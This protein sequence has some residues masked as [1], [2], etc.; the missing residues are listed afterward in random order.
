MLTIFR[1]RCL[2]QVIL[3]YLQ[4]STEALDQLEKW[5]TLRQNTE[6]KPAVESAL[7]VLKSESPD[8][9]SLLQN[10]VP[11]LYSRPYLTRLIIT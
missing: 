11:L 4:P 3:C 7:E 2:A 1:G 6:C 8:G 9:M 10:L 5:G